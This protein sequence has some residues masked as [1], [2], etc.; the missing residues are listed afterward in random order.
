MPAIAYDHARTDADLE[1]ILALQRANLPEALTAEEIRQ[2]GFLTVRHDLDLLRRMNAP[3]PHIVARD[4][5]GIAGY[6]LVMLP[7]MEP[8]IPILQP[9]FEKIRTLRWQ[10]RPIDSLDWFVMGQ[11]CVARRVRGTGVFDG[12][13][14][15]M[16]QRMAAHFDCVITEISL[17][18]RRSLRA[19]ARVGFQTILEYT[20]PSGEAWA[21]V[22]WDWQ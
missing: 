22:L 16:R 4:A 14:R 11:V 9:M 13:Y 3:W 21:T 18:N 1:G 10:G 17:R 12:L 5:E 2:Q 15:H 7:E 6:A 20:D 8:E 19:H